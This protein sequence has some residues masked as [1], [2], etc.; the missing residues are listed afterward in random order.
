MLRSRITISALAYD[1]AW[2]SERLPDKH[3][4]LLTPSP[5]T[6]YEE[7]AELERR[8]LAEL[9]S[10]GLARGEQIHP[11]LL[12]ALRLIAR[13]HQEFYGWWHAAE[14]DTVSAVVAVSGEDAVRAVLLNN[15]LTL[16]PVRAAGAADALV[17]LLPQAPAGR[18]S[19]ISMP[20]D[21]VGGSAGDGPGYGGGVMVSAS[22]S[23]NASTA[24]LRRLLDQ[25]RTGGG[26]LYAASRDHLG[27]KHR[28]PGPVTY[29]DTAAGRYVAVR[30][31]GSD[32][33]A[34]VTITPA[35]PSTLASRLTESLATR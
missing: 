9:A 15:Q 7:R 14:S 25:P 34:W 26:Q 4:A 16:E 1:V 28:A 24:Q 13:A 6:T 33:R 27:R 23:V 3:R 22:T 10:L 2:E 29:F 30:R 17:A 21:E 18:G 12:A 20:E 31:P 35:D 11:D 32:G 5:G 8:A 19:A